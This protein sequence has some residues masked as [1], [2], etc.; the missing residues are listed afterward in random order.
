MSLE[1]QTADEYARYISESVAALAMLKDQ[2]CGMYAALEQKGKNQSDHVQAFANAEARLRQLLGQFPQDPITLAGIN[3]ASARVETVAAQLPKDLKQVMDGLGG[4]VAGSFSEAVKPEIERISD[5]ATRATQAAHEYVEQARHSYWKTAM[6]ALTVSLVMAGALVAGALYW[7]IPARAD[8]E[9]QKAEVAR[10][11]ATVAQL[12]QQGGDA[13][14]VQC[15]TRLC[16]RTDETGKAPK[17]AD[18]KKGETYRV[19]KGY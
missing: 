18:A 11:T 12:K 17:V 19:I 10:L 16:V 4:R 15:E 7:W 5:A 13:Q 9:A 2:I 14:V 3:Q 8:V 6:L 1:K